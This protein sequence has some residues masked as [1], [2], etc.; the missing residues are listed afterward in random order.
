MQIRPPFRAEHIGSLLRPPQLLALR[1]EAGDVGQWSSM[2]L[3][4]QERI[5]ISYYDVSGKDLKFAFFDGSEWGKFIVDG[6]YEDVGMYT[7]LTLDVGG[8]PHITYYDETHQQLMHATISV[9][10]LL[11]GTQES[12]MEPR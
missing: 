1:A 6:E 2:A 7:S 9:G 3:D 10:T 11:K 4:S 8:N 5:Y 12:Q